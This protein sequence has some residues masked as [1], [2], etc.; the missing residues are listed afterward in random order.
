MIVSTTVCTNTAI[1]EKKDQLESSHPVDSSAR[2]K[3]DSSHPAHSS[4]IFKSPSR[5]IS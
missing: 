1:T 5:Q 4:A 3:I 2:V